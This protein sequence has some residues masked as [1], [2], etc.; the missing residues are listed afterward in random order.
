MHFTFLGSSGAVPARERD[1]TSIVFV[2]DGDAVLVDCGGSPM[3]KLLL[4]GVAPEALGRVVITHI[5]ADHVYGL[6]SLVETLYLLGRRTPLR[7]AYRE[8]HEG[9]LRALLGVFRQ[10]ERP[11]IFPIVWEPV[12][13]RERFALESLG[14][15]AVSASPNAHGK[16]PNL[17]VRFEPFGGPAV[18]YSSDTEP[19]EAVVALARGAHTLI[20]EATFSERRPKGV[21]VH[22]TAAEA[23]EIAARAGVK[24]LILAHI[25]VSHH[26]DLEGHGEEARSRFSG[27]VEVAQELVPYPL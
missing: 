18:V 9:A 27:E 2:G 26:G 22:S 12:P 14:S 19:C 10:L 3:Q 17:A 11:E 1:T 6:P 13:A 25:D 4:A 23:G 7:L 24:R 21:G 5:H 8:E 16:M 15:F 20:H